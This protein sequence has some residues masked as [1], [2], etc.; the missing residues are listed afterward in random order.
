MGRSQI[1]RAEAAGIEPHTDMNPVLLKPEAGFAWP[2]P[3]RTP[4]RSPAASPS[5]SFRTS[6]ISTS[7][8]SSPLAATVPR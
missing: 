8:R 6:P 2:K 1:A 7:L 3:P 4:S 5:F